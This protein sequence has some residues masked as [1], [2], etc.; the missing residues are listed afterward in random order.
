MLDASFSIPFF[1]LP[2]P[3]PIFLF[4]LSLP[5][6]LLLRSADY[7]IPVPSPADHVLW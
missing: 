4:S 6:S 7:T 2:L 3:G 5:H 1:L